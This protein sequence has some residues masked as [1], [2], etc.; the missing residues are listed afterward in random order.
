MRAVSLTPVL[1]LTFC[2]LPLAAQPAMPR[3][4]PEHDALKRFVGDW[5]ATVVFMGGE[6][7]GTAT[8]KLGFG[9]FWLTENFKS[10]FGG[11][12]FEGRATVGYDPTK[13]K[14]VSTWIDSMTPSLL[15]M[16][17]EYTNDGKTY[18]ES[19]VG[20]GH[21]GKPTKIK[22]VYEFKDEDAFVFTMYMGGSEQEG[23]KI[24]YKRKK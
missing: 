2:A 8:Y 15:I 23:L 16:E 17:G 11:Q 24:T 6:S 4:G 20:P 21:D 1:L 10:D 7:K 22:S 13:K 18:T 19:G 5:D 14:Y 3:P 9:G 12:K